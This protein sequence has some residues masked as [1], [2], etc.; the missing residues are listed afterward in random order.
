VFSVSA[1]VRYLF[2]GFTT[3]DT[4]LHRERVLV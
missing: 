4:E 3:A 1:V 2:G